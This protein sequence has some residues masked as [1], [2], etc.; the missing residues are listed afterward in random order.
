[1]D[2]VPALKDLQLL[3]QGA[4]FQT[5]PRGEVL[6]ASDKPAKL[7]LVMSG[8]VKR[9]FI[10]HDGD[11]GV[12]AIY[13]PGDIFPFTV[14]FRALFNQEIYQGP[15][16]YYYETMTSLGVYGMDTATLLQNIELYPTLYRVLF[17]SAGMR[18]HSNIQFLENLRMHGAYSKTAHQLAYF[19]H[20]FGK[21]TY[22]GIRIQLPLTHQ[23]LADIIGTTRETVTASIIKLRD[24]KLIKT[25][26]NILIL[27]YDRLINEA[28]L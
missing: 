23:D 25:D 5:I 17:Q 28:Y 21:K 27:D 8:F 10:A 15:E 14:V 18:F 9:Y 6:Y 13:G 20:R 22:K 11:L 26:R 16:V 12:Q 2:T 4:K 7:R 1:M 19:G 24:K 3:F